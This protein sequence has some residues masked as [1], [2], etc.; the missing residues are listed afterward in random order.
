MLLDIQD[1]ATFFKLHRALM[2]FV[3][4]RLNVLS[5]NVSTPDEFSNLAPQSRVRVREAWLATPGLIDDFVRDNTGKFTD[6][7]LEIVRSW[8]SAVKSRFCLFRELKRH[9][10]LIDLSPPHH[11]YEVLALSQP[12]SELLADRTIPATIETVLL[13]FRGR[14]VY[15]GILAKF[16]VSFGPGVRRALATAYRDAKALHNVV[17]SLSPAEAPQA[18]TIPKPRKKQ[19]T[20]SPS[21]PSKSRSAEV[22]RLVDDFCRDH[23]NKEYAEICHR[24]AEKLS[25][26]R[27][28]PLLE[29]RPGGWASGIVRAVGGIN[30][31]HD[32]SQTPHMLAADI[33]QHFGVS[34]ATGSAKAASIR[35]ALRLSPYDEE[36]MLTKI[37]ARIPLLK[38]FR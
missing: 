26:K 37:A 13:P 21:D 7:E 10:V 15:D 14:I 3:N 38:F 11:I 35:T 4:Q 30:F 6:E 36:W 32:K 19:T 5:E 1:L 20:V 34:H 24:M 23:L 12:M 8:K 16:T 29:G 17:N 27:P 18:I 25:R 31:L 2:F 28:S 9:A 33:D 22:I